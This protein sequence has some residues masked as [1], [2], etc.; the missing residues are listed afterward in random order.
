[1][2]A[3]AARKTL[4]PADDQPFDF[5]LDAVAAEVDLAPWRVHFGGRRWEFKH[6]QEI[7][8][9]D[10]MDRDVK[11]ETGAMLAVFETALGPDQ[12]GEFRKIPLP[13]YKLK[14]LFEAYQ[15]YGGVEPGESEGSTA[16]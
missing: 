6:P 14:A 12:F 11:S 9:W 2:T 4:K 5:N 8:V 13:S 10:V 3:A 15:K 16:S 1:M 7:D